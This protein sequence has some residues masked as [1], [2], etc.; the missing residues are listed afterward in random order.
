MSRYAVIAL[1]LAA[2]SFDPGGTLRA[3]DEA[4]DASSVTSDGAQAGPTDD[5]SPSLPIDA[6]SSSPLDAEPMDTGCDEESD[7]P[8]QLCCVYAGGWSSACE[9]QC[10]WGGAQVCDDISDCT[11]NDRCCDHWFGP[12]TCGWCL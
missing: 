7:C 12:N 1:L 10:G 3:G 6:A 2:C 5:A 4:A 8:G 11:G 9:A